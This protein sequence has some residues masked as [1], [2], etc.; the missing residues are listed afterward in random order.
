MIPSMIHIDGTSRPQFVDKNDNKDF[1]KLLKYIKK[2]KKYGVVL[3]T[4][5][6]LHGRAM[7]RTPQDAIDDFLDCKIDELYICGYLITKN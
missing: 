3:N 2:K 4:S 1:F 7:V 6:N 5:F